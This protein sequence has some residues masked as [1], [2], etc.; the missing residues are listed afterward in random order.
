MIWFKVLAVF[1]ILLNILFLTILFLSFVLRTYRN[2]FPRLQNLAPENDLPRVNNNNRAGRYLDL[3]PEHYQHVL[4]R[5]NN[6]R[7]NN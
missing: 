2:E 7:R 6:A 5:Q 1:L 4:R 3:R